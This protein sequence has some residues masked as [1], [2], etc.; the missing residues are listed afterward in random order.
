MNWSTLVKAAA[1]LGG[2]NSKK[3][4]L[5]SANYLVI[6]DFQDSI[7]NRV[8]QSVGWKLGCQG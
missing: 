6:A 8:E 2:V 1:R 7:F 3:K 4:P 5:E